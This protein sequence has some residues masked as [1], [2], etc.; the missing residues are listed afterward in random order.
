M[1]VRRAF[2]TLLVS[3]LAFAAEPPVAPAGTKAAAPASSSASTPAGPPSIE[4]LVQFV[5]ED[6]LALKPEPPIAL[7][8][9]SPAPELQRA[10]GTVLASRLAAEE[11]GPVV[12]NAPSP[13]AAE[14]LARERGARSLV[15]I[16]VSVQGGEVSARGDVLGTW[17][18]FWSGDTPSRPTTPAAALARSVEADSGALALAAISPLTSAS[19][20]MAVA[21]GPRAV[22]LMGA[23][24]IHLEQAPAALAA[25]DLDGDGKDEVIVLTERAVSVFADDGRLLAQRDFDSLP[26]SATPPRE[27]FGTVAIIPQPARIAAWSARYSHGEVL[28]FD[29]PKGALRPLGPLDSAPLGANERGTFTQ[30]QTTFIAEVRLGE[31][32]ILNVPA[33]FTTASMV[34]PRMLFVHLDGSASLY[35]RPTAPPIRI[36][37]LGAGSTLGDLDGDG[38]PEL[39]TTS[40][41]VFP[42]PDVVRVFPLA[43]DDPTTHGVL[44]QSALPPGRAL[45]VVTADLDGDKHREVLV[46]LA[47][48]DGSGEVFLMRQGAP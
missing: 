43:G 20:P 22:R 10:F 47:L 12:L 44:W 40:P 9:S 34:P 30:G 45:Q 37:G 27:P 16:T 5:A 33:P 42:V 11:M 18:N 35:P 28:V 29:K 21:S 39:I 25:G 41:Q 46:G 36:Q 38:T 8:L 13:E 31:G 14:T 15:R 24:M 2:A 7:H 19:S 4:Q 1:T 26:P 17:V 23:V 32:R 6:V 48:P 3:T